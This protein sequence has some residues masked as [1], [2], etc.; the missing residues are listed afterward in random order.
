MGRQM[1]VQFIF[2]PEASVR[3]DTIHKTS[4]QPM[5]PIAHP[6]LH[7]RLL[8]RSIEGTCT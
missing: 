1:R 6:A 4:M 8:Q 5:Q 2:G 7:R 3:L